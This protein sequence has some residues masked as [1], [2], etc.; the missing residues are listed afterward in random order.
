MVI[1]NRHGVRIERGWERVPYVSSHSLLWLALLTSLLLV[2]SCTSIR[3]VVKIG[4]LAPFEG[5]DRRSGYTVLDATRAAISGMAAAVDVIPL[6]LDT[7]TDARRASQ[8]VLQDDNVAAIIGPLD[9][10]NAHKM[11]D[12]VTAEAVQW[13][14]PFAL[15]ASGFTDPTDPA[16]AAA[17]M[18]AVANTAHGQGV[19]RL[20]VAGWTPG[21]PALDATIWQRA[22]ALPVTF[23][24][25]IDAVIDGDAIVWLGAPDAGA[26]FFSD[27]RINGSAAS[28]WLVNQSSQPLFVEH[29]QSVA[30]KTWGDVF[31]AMWLPVGYT[32]QT[33][34]PP[35]PISISVHAATAQALAQ[36]LDKASPEQV[37]QVQVVQL[38]QT[39]EIQPVIAGE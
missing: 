38:S 26:R 28:F 22:F 11:V 16:W 27:L 18:D 30:P 33:T 36:V 25:D 13:I 17:M 5:L 39:G 3:P 29:A 24:T 34:Q 20:V 7:S 15:T 14:A 1:S 12:V 21:W 4:L 35:S 31:W 37:W 23:F 19:R 6:A 9:P 8:K 32:L 2:T 10:Q